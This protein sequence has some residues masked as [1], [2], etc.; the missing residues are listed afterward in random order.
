MLALII[1]LFGGIID[2][3]KENAHE[4]KKNVVNVILVAT[5]WFAID[6]IRNPIVSEVG[7]YR[8]LPATTKQLVTDVQEIKTKQEE[9]NQKLDEIQKA[10]RASEIDQAGWVAWRDDVN[11]QLYFLNLSAQRKVSQTSEPDATLVAK[12][13]KQD[14]QIR[15]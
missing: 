8:V 6:A 5:I 9:T 10:I 14:A 3:V 1:R 4:A 15:F 11:R 7:E 2:L 13:N 12:N